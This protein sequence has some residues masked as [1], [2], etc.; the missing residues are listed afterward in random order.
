[1]FECLLAY[2]PELYWGKVLDLLGIWR[3]ASFA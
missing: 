2:G 3:G 1:M